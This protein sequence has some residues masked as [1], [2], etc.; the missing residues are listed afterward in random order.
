LAISIMT[1]Q[2][3]LWPNGRAS[4]HDT[5]DG[6]FGRHSRKVRP[7]SSN[8]CGF[9]KRA[10]ACK[11]RATVLIALRRLSVMPALMYFGG[12]SNVASA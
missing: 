1:Y 11:R 8:N 2:S 6:C 10:G 9:G 5:S 4:A 7:N 12:H 3:K